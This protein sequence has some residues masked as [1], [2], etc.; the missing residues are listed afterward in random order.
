M[1]SEA[2]KAF[3]LEWWD[4]TEYYMKRMRRNN[5]KK[6]E[7][8]AKRIQSVIETSPELEWWV[9]V[10]L[11]CADW[12]LLAWIKDIWFNFSYTW[13][14]ISEDMIWIAKEKYRNIEFKVW[15]ALIRNFEDDMVS[16]YMLS[17]I[18]HELY[19]YFGK[20][21]DQEWIIKSL[22][23]IKK[24]LKTNWVILVKDPIWPNMKFDIIQWNFRNLSPYIEKA[25]LLNLE[26]QSYN[27]ADSSIIHLDDTTINARDDNTQNLSWTESLLK[28]KMDFLEVYLSKIWSSLD[29]LIA[30]TT[31]EIERVN[32]IIMN[33]IL[34]IDITNISIEDI[35]LL[36]L[37]SPPNLLWR[38]LRMIR[39]IYE[40]KPARD[41][42][43][44]WILKIWKNWDFKI[45]RWLLSEVARHL[46]P[47]IWRT[48]RGWYS[49]LME[50]YWPLNKNE[51]LE[52]WKSLWFEVSVNEIYKENSHASWLN[53]EMVLSDLEWNQLLQSKILPTHQYTTFRKT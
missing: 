37:V 23:S 4:S 11:W 42:L 26:K 14:D 48:N 18:L 22:M 35:H 38:K 41:E 51:I 32:N 31:S 10:D 9:L 8:F 3:K 53:D 5:E 2:K 7:H 39:F 20:W 17:S 29:K 21:F 25:E 16:I 33:D 40:F 13:V 30:W 12:D 19:S 6:V 24:S 50:F 36:Q 49:E 52:L 15:D 46:S 28:E 34:N 27:V 43:H 1:K 47:G 45:S 44:D